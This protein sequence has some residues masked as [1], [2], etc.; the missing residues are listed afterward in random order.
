MNA[1]NRMANL[2]AMI[3]AP[4]WSGKWAPARIGA[5][6]SFGADLRNDS[7]SDNGKAGTKG[8]VGTPSVSYKI[9]FPLPI[10]LLGTE[11]QPELGPSWRVDGR[12]ARPQRS[13]AEPP[14]ILPPSARLEERHHMPCQ[15]IP[16]REE[17]PGEPDGSAFQ[18]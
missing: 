1:A 4:G 7:S 15:E 18:V 8:T 17:P 10:V 3:G 12:R 13:G 5:R 16:V 14:P 9:G 6:P 2:R 11:W